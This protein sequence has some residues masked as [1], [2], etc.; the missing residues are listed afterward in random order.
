MFSNRTATSAWRP[1]FSRAKARLD[2]KSVREFGQSMLTLLD[3]RRLD[4]AFLDR[5]VIRER[6]KTNLI[7]VDSIDCIESAGVYVALHVGDER[8]IHRAALSE[9]IGRSIHAASFAFIALPSSTSIAFCIWSPH[10]TA[11]SILYCVAVNVFTSVGHF[12]PY[13]R[14]VWGSPYDEGGHNPEGLP[15]MLEIGQL[16]VRSHTSMFSDLVAPTQC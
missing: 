11:N 14:L 8:I 15:S 4:S 7:R 10:R 1:P 13:S 6:D 16:D 9:L 12:D 2:D 3:G 5:I